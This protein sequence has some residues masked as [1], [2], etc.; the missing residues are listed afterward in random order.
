MRG[1]SA[2]LAAAPSTSLEAGGVDS[3]VGM[4]SNGG[5]ELHQEPAA[6]RETSAAPELRPPRENPEAPVRQ[7]RPAA[8]VA[9]FEPTP[10]TEGGT[11]RESKPY[12]VWSSAPPAP[13]TSGSE[14]GP[15]E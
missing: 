12:V 5:Q 15:E 13:S 7:E 14:R 9:H 2:S 10:P 11:A 8:P 1:E 6:V 3:S 4:H